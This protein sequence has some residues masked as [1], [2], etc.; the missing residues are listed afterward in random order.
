MT[1]GESVKSKAVKEKISKGEKYGLSRLS[2][3]F[4]G[5]RQ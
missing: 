1:G 2:C 4:V 3:G 5:G